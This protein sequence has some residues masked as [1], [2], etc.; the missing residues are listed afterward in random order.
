MGN[1]NSSKHVPESSPVVCVLQAVLDAG[2]LSYLGVLLRHIKK[3][4]RKVSGG[5]PP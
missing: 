5:H 2:V 3:N 4:I 1:G